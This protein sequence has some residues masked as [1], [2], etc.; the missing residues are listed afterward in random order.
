LH[1]SAEPLRHPIR[2]GLSLASC[3]LIDTLI[4]A[5]AFPVTS[6]LLCVHAIAITPDRFNGACSSSTSIAS[7]LPRETVRS[8]P[9]IVF[10]EACSPTLRPAGS[11][12]RQAPFT[13]R[14]PTALLPPLPPRLLPG[15]ANQFPG[16]S[17][18]RCSPAPFTAHCFANNC[19]GSRISLH[20]H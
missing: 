19:F 13:P 16:G 6:G 3:Q 4:T 20:L 7:G 1:R 12:S 8:A 18:T 9:A 15:G 14:A 5:G 2:P 17:C 10:F 11:R